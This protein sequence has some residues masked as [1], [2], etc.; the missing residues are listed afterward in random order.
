MA[1]VRPTDR[2][3]DRAASRPKLCDLF[4]GPQAPWPLYAS[5][6]IVVVLTVSRNRWMIPPA[7][8]IA[9]K[10]K[11]KTA[12]MNEAAAGRVLFLRT[13]LLLGFLNLNWIACS[14]I[15]QF[16]TEDRKLNVELVLLA[17]FN[18]TEDFT[19][20]PYVNRFHSFNSS[21]SHVVPALVLKTC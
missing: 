16:Y 21:S 4:R 5:M 14:S 18:Y 3:S 8:E 20:K 9:Q 2:P 11:I 12:A 7:Y 6:H 1:T 17:F 13:K 19:V 10:C 15:M